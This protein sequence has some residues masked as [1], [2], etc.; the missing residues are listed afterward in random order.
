[1]TES[2]PEPYSRAEMLALSENRDCKHPDGVKFIGGSYALACPAC[3]MTA[4]EIRYGLNRGPSP[5]AAAFK[6]LRG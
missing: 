5:L 6:R 4:E 1:M 2:N 3:G